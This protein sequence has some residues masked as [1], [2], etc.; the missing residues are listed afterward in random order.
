MQH[1]VCSMIS[2]AKVYCFY[3]NQCQVFI[4]TKMLG[5]VYISILVFSYPVYLSHVCLESEVEKKAF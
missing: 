2:S 1:E 4:I 3:N 5:G